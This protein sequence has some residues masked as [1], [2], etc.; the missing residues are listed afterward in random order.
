V[1]LAQYNNHIPSSWNHRFLWHVLLEI[2]QILLLNL[3]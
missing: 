1:V 2:P 3:H